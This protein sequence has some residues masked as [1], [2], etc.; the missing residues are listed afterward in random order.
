MVMVKPGLPYLD[1]ISA[2]KETFQVPTFAFHVSGEYGCL[3]LMQEAG[4]MDFK[5]AFHEVLVSF[6]RAGCDGILT[7]GALEY[8][9]S[10]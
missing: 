3:K 4:F 6:K 9:R 10:Q 5:R 2:I 1:V 7:Y 8:A